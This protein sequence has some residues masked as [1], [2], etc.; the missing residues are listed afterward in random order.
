MPHLVHVAVGKLG[1]FDLKAGY[2]LY[3]GSALGGLAARLARHCRSEKRLH[4]HIDYLTTRLEVQEAWI[5]K[6][7]ERLE[8]ACAEVLRSLSGAELPILGFGS[9]DC[10]CVTHLV[11]FPSL[12]S[13][14]VFEQALGWGTDHQPPAP[15]P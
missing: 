15:N 5:V 7:Q 1:E 8:C 9:S 6:R 10:R 12:P 3:A 14:D 4:W 11:Y 13:P 2:Y